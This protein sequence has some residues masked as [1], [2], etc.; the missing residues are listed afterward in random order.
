MV[1]INPG[2]LE[3]LAHYV[4]TTILFTL[5]T[6][7]IVVTIQEHTSLHEKDAKLHQRAAWPYLFLRRWMLEKRTGSNSESEK[8]VSE[9]NATAR[10]RTASPY[11]YSRR[12]RRET[13]ADEAGRAQT[14]NGKI[15]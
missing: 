1:E 7:Y 14:K 3:T 12:R 10:Q 4:E 8:V 13:E 9:E 11:R 6:V 2:S 15:V 5:L